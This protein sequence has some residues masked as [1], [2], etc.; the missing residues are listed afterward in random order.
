LKPALRPTAKQVS[1]E[2]SVVLSHVAGGA[3]EA[4]IQQEVAGLPGAKAAAGASVEDL[5]EF[6]GVVE[7]SHASSASIGSLVSRGSRDLPPVQEHEVLQTGESSDGGAAPSPRS[8][9]RPQRQLAHPKY[10]PTPLSTEVLTLSYLLLQW[11]FS[12]TGSACCWLHG[13][14]RSLDRVRKELSQR[15]CITQQESVICGQCDSCGLLMIRGQSCC[16]FCAEELSVDEAALS[17]D[18]LAV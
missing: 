6:R 7:V 8:H 12:A 16:E 15:A 9:G 2:L 18:V 17:E 10:K 4:V 1:D 3:A 5:Q 11:N 14:L 13:A